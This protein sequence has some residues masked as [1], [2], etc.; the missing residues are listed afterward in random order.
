MDSIQISITAT[1]EEQEILISLLS[2]LGAPVLNKQ[3][4]KLLHILMKTILK[5]TR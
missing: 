3:I 4:K 1:E 2:D 5:A